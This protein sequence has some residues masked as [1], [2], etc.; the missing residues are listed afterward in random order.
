MQVIIGHPHARRRSTC[1]APGRLGTPV[2]QWTTCTSK[3]G[4]N[5]A[6][7][8]VCQEGL[9]RLNSCRDGAVAS[10]LQSE[11]YLGKVVE[12]RVPSND[13]LIRRS[14]PRV[15]DPWRRLSR[16]RHPFTVANQHVGSAAILRALPVESTY[17]RAVGRSGSHRCRVRR[18]HASSWGLD[19]MASGGVQCARV[20][21]P[22]SSSGP[23]VHK[24]GEDRRRCGPKQLTGVWTRDMLNFQKF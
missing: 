11:H 17:A 13:Q 22:T 5:P 15:C 23:H 8:G 2:D 10:C 3:L 1:P 14:V 6:F 24:E 18:A 7:V 4:K 19:T 20:R 9:P 21:A 12:A 16:T